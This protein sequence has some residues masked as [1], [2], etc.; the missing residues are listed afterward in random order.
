[1]ITDAVLLTS[2][3]EFREKLK[4]DDQICLF[5]NL[6]IGGWCP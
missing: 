3:E 2:D 1:M 5:K 4:N 6:E